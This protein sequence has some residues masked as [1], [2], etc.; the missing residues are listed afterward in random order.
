LQAEI[1]ERERRK[2]P[3]TAEKKYRGIFENAVEGIFR[4]HPMEL[5]RS[6]HARPHLWLFREDLQAAMTDIGTCLYVDPAAAPNF[7]GASRGTVSFTALNL[8]RHKGWSCHLDFRTPARQ[9]S[10]WKR[11]L[12]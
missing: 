7:S 3:C 2:S 8:G 1:A 5:R 6:T 12:L 11:P 4:A 9:G 10:G